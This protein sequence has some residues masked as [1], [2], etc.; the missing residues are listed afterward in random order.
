[1][2][3]KEYWLT[4][5]QLDLYDKILQYMEEHKMNKTQLSE[6]LGCSKGYVTQILSGDYNH[7]LSK[8][9]ELAL[10][11]GIVPEVRFTDIEE[12]IK[13]DKITHT[14]R[15][16]KCVMNPGSFSSECTNNIKA[17]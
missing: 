12:Y 15:V 3:S 8:F 9:V 4:T 2:R 5:I 14:S 16:F 10:S 6:H 13:K 1:M 7:T 11:V 17:A